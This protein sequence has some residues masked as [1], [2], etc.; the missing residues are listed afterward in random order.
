MA[1]TRKSKLLGALA[2]VMVASA[3]A[4]FWH[5]R[6]WPV[7]HFAVVEEGV[8]YRCAQPEQTGWERLRDHYHIKTVIDL[9]EERPKQD[10]FVLEREFL[11]DNG[12]R[13]IR[14]PI[15]SDHMTPEE[16]KTVVDTIN[17]PAN[18]PVLIHCEL[19]KARTGVAVA[20][21][22]ITV[23][24]WDYPAALEEAT[25]FNEHIKPGYAAYLKEL[26]ESHH[27]AQ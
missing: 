12:I 7:N 6:N 3:A 17:D 18:R 15:G 21:Y 13:H 9:R 20:A 10:W 1:L 5:F 27:S 23:K 2:L 11:K 8:L 22:L 19:G 25:K 24:G 14:L 26:A 16:L 4:A